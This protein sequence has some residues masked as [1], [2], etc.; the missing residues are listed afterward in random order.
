[1]NYKPPTAQGGRGLETL[2]G[3]LKSPSTQVKI[4]GQGF[5]A[6]CAA[7]DPHKDNVPG[8]GF[9]KRRAPSVDGDQYWPRVKP[10]DWCLDYIAHNGGGGQ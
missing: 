2:A 5:C 7:F 9:C 4:S 3:N 10:G 6:I 8:F 1:M